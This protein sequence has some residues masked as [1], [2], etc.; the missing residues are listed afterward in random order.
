MTEEVMGEYLKETNEEFKKSLYQ[1][2][3]CLV[4]K[5]KKIDKKNKI[6][7]RKWVWFFL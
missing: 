1:Q 6:R 3:D 2:L 4:K 7:F 5:Y